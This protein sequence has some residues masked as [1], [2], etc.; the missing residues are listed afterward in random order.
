MAFMTLYAVKMSVL[1]FYH[2][3][4]FVKEA[5]RRAVLILMVIS[6][7]WLIAIQI[8]NLLTCRPVDAYWHR[9]KEQRCAS[10]NVFLLVI[11]ITDTI[12]DFVIVILPI[13]M[14]SE[15]QL[16]MRTKVAVGGMF[17]LG[18]FVVVTDIVRLVSSYQ[19]GEQ[20]GMC[21][22]VKKEAKVTLTRSQ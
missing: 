5:C 12:L 13:H 6:T 1:V 9:D 2:R 14:A 20:Y 11:N 21:N 15:L 4:I 17:G 8:A 18:G 7:I 3:F 22:W 10:V 19:R 16:P